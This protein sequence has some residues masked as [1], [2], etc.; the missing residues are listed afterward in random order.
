MGTC[1]VTNSNIHNN[2]A[3]SG[4]GGICNYG[5]CTV[6]GSNIT[7]NTA[8]FGGGIYNSNDCNV[9]FNRFYNNNATSGTAIY[10]W[11]G[12][13]N[14]ENNWWGN[15]TN[16]KNINNM[17]AGQIDVDADPWL[18]MIFTA[19]PTTINPGQTSTLTASFNI[20]SNNN[21]VG[22]AT[23][24]IPDGVP[25]TF[26]TNLGNVGSKSVDNYTKDGNTTAV[27]RADEGTG[28]AITAA[29]A[30]SQN[31]LEAMF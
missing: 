11:L 20:N 29:Y 8:D 23:N 9:N 24:H 26:T 25:V 15:N 30:D 4:G 18:I 19:N 3:P 27:L 17:I 1:T 10:N 2:T 31:P 7:N 6:T 14:A 22:D 21:T 16:P 28:T 5:T 13:V 12:T